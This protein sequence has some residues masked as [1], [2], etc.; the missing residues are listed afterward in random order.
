MLRLATRAVFLVF[1]RLFGLQAASRVDEDWP[2]ARRGF[3][4]Y[5]A[6]ASNGDDGYLGAFT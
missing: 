4:P 1:M 2:A 6:I 3:E 5:D